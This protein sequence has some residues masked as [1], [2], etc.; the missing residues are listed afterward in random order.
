MLLHENVLVERSAVEERLAGEHHV[1]TEALFS[2]F[3][4]VLD[5]G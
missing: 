4:A 2:D 1:W 3:E 5:H